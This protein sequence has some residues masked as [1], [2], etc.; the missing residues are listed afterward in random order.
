MRISSSARAAALTLALFAGCSRASRDPL[1]GAGATFPYPVYSR[2]FSGWLAQ[3]G[4]SI[5]YFSVGSAEGIRRLAAGEA[6]F[7]ATD[8]L[9]DDPRLRAFAARCGA[10]LRVPTVLGAVAVGYAL[11]DSALRLDGETLAAIFLG[12][13][14]RWDDPRLRALNPGR[15]LPALPIAVVAR[16]DGSG[17]ATVFDGF[18]ARQSNAWRIARA[19]A[20]E[21]PHWPV[22]T[23]VAGNEGV[24][25][26]IRSLPGAIGFLELSYAEQNRIAVAAI[27]NAAGSF[28]APSVASISAAG[29]ERL[30]LDRADT[31]RSLLDVRSPS[32]Y[33]I[34]SLT[35][36]LIPTGYRDAERGTNLIAFVRWAIT[37]SPH[38]RAPAL[39]YAPLPGPVAASVDQALRAVRPTTC[40]TS[41]KE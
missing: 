18:L 11:P 22:G 8:G 3:G 35:W 9:G 1:V 32:A 31:V 16:A 29:A 33:P 10:V 24:A 4:R 30:T 25:A 23:R 5:N 36:L 38:T 7:A 41:P 28:V 27:R 34:S 26:A 40:A 19:A 21:L 39:E 6:D 20:L 12:R 14:T 2:W 37:Q 15:P 13:I 17:T